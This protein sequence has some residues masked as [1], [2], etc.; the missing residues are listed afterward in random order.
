MP[1]QAASMYRG[2]ALKL[3][4]RARKPLIIEKQ[5]ASAEARQYDGSEALYDCGATALGNNRD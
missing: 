4:N 2:S 1:R 5:V 3:S